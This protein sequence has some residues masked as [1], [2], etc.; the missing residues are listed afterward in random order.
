MIRVY[1][2]G[3]DIS[4]SLNRQYPLPESAGDGIFPS[5]ETGKWYNLLSCIDENETLKENFF[6]AS[7][8]YGGVHE[9]TV[10]NP[11]GSSFTMRVILRSKYSARNH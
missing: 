2:D 8:S 3:Q 11:S 6:N 1:L 7:G 9:L 10:V 4:D 5:R